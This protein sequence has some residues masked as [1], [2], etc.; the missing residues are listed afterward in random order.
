MSGCLTFRWFLADVVMAMKPPIWKTYESGAG[1]PRLD[2]KARF[3]HRSSL[4]VGRE[5]NLAAEIERW[6]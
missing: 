5:I 3:H 1:F 6:E 4:V 2:A